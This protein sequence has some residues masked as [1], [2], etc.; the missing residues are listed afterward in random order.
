MKEPAAEIDPTKKDA[1]LGT[2]PIGE[3]PELSPKRERRPP[4]PDFSFEIEAKDALEKLDRLY[5][6][7]EAGKAPSEEERLPDASEEI[8]AEDER[9][10]EEVHAELE[11]HKAEL[12]NDPSLGPEY[13]LDKACQDSAHFLYE[14]A[15]AGYD[16]EDF[17]RL[18]KNEVKKIRA[19]LDPSIVD[20]RI[21][22]EL[23]ARFQ[24]ERILASKPEPRTKT[25]ELDLVAPPES[26]D[27]T[28]E[29]RLP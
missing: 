3:V 7:I 19:E 17:L 1:T 22:D 29:T 8:T 18:A 15:A 23:I 10:L 4:G 27:D 20:A 16:K 2:R 24:E 9:E 13:H 5:D 26:G 28:E 12:K 6:E 21:M 11:R 14:L 25:V